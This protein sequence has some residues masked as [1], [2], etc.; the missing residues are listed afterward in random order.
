MSSNYSVTFPQVR[1]LPLLGNRIDYHL[2]PE[3]SRDGIF[4]EVTLGA[5]TAGAKSTLI[6]NSMRELSD[7]EIAA[8]D[9]GANT[10]FDV[11]GAAVDNELIGTVNFDFSAQMKNVL[12]IFPDS[13]GV[14][15]PA[16]LKP[17]ITV[18]IK[19]AALRIS[20]VDVSKKGI[21]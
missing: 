3:D 8:I 20:K 13:T 6:I 7:A 16:A 5:V 9:G 15:F 1:I 21:H 12:R 2:T 19:D 14:V 10:F 11:N 4:I 17:I 18:I